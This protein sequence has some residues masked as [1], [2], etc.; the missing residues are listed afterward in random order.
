M[1]DDRTK[2][3]QEFYQELGKQELVR[4]IM[5]LDNYIGNVKAA[6]ETGGLEK[7]LEE[8]I[9][10]R[11]SFAIKYERL[12]MTDTLKE[13]QLFTLSGAGWRLILEMEPRPERN[14]KELETAITVLLKEVQEY[15]EA[16]LT[17]QFKSVCL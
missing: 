13:G 7:R 5:R 16:L 11:D 9:R 2:E 6:I 1:T 15:F 17:G 4:R 14:E 8:A 3:E 10:E 12:N